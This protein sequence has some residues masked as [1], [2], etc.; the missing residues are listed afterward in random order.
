[1]GVVTYCFHKKLHLQLFPVFKMSVQPKPREL[2]IMNPDDGQKQ[3]VAEPGI[4]KIYRDILDLKNNFSLYEFLV[5]LS[6][7]FIPSAWDMGTDFKFAQNLEIKILA[8]LS[9]LI[10]SLPGLVYALTLLPMVL[11]RCCKHCKIPSIAKSMF[12]N[13]TILF[14]VLGAGLVI[15]AFVAQGEKTTLLFN[16]SAVIVAT[17]L[18]AVKL[19]GVLVHSLDIKNLNV[20]AT[21]YE[22]SY[23]SSLQLCLILFVW[24]YGLG[25]LDVPAMVSSLFML[26]KSGAENFLTFGLENKLS[27]RGTLSKLK[28]VGQFFPVFLATAMFRIGSISAC[29]SWDYVMIFI[30]LLP[31]VLGLPLI[32]VILLKMCGKLPH[33]SLADVM[34]GIIGEVTSIVLWGN[35]G[36]E[37]SRNIQLWIGGYLLI[38]YTTILGLVFALPS[39]SLFGSPYISG[40]GYGYGFG[41]GNH[42]DFEAPHEQVFCVVCLVCGWAGYLLFIYQ[43]YFFGGYKLIMKIII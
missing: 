21:A 20:K 35:T 33:L 28:L 29:G 14:M 1:M 8:N 6:F 3:K 12:T 23:E 31:L 24:L 19:L 5:Q 40:Y 38:I 39:G 32:T 43:I 30:I 13:V 7:G 18:L 34:Q 11:E 27:D 37:G 16:I 9:Y 2:Q 10:I 17:V 41:S 36:R 25:E 42:T 22:G 26:G 15:L 4:R